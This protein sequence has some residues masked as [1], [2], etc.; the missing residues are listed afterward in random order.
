[1]TIDRLGFLGDGLATT[2]EGEWRVPLALPGERWRV[3]PEAREGRRRRASALER[4]GDASAD[5]IEPPCPHF[6]RCGG[7]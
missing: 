2:E 6:G 7:C 3:R 4:L 1:M 5:R